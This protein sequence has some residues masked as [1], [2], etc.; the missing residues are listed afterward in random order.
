ML[1]ATATGEAEGWL[2]AEDRIYSSGNPLTAIDISPSGQE[3]LASTIDKVSM[4]FE[5][6]SSES[7]A[8][9]GFASWEAQVLGQ[10]GNLPFNGLVMHTAFSPN[11]KML[12]TAGQSGDLRIWHAPDPRDILT[13][14]IRL[15]GHSTNRPV[16]CSV[17]SPDSTRIISASED[18]TARLWDTKTGNCIFT[19]TVPSQ[20][21][22]STSGITSCCFTHNG[23]NVVLGCKDGAVRIYPIN[24]KECVL[25]LQAPGRRSGD[26][27]VP[28][29]LDCSPDGRFL[30]SADGDGNCYLWD[31]STGRLTASLSA[32]HDIVFCARFSPDGKRILSVNKQGFADIWRVESPEYYTQHSFL[33]HPTYSIR[34]SFNPLY[35]GQ[36]SPDGHFIY[37]GGK[38]GIVRKIAVSEEAL[39][40]RARWLLSRDAQISSYRPPSGLKASSTL[41]FP[42]Y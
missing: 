37:V 25:T 1:T 33:N 7:R 30:L 11:G 19:Y 10:G 16:N 42:H 31:L 39:L 38:D 3:V 32:Y 40:Q 28:W 21:S 6:W 22:G 35:A 13:E 2:L 12:A 14:G 4:W 8:R 20:H 5:D 26:Y 23:K 9:N 29:S 41:P 24:N 18:G 34:V 17:F 15:V 36:F 27:A